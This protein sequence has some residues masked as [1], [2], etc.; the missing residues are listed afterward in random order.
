[1]EV[2]YDTEGVIDEDSEGDGDG[3]A[4]TIGA[5][6]NGALY[7]MRDEELSSRIRSALGNCRRPTLWSPITLQKFSGPRKI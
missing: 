3:L 6:S 7:G 1:M 4:V 2:A 5:L